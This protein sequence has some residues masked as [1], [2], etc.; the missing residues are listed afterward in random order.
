MLETLKFAVKPGKLGGSVVSH[1]R[2]G[3]YGDAVVQKSVAFW[4]FKRS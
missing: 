1:F 4:Q 2:G 3:E